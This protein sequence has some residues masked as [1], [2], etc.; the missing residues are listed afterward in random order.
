MEP[1]TSGVTDA[2]THAP[3]SPRSVSED[4][5]ARIK[6]CKQHLEN[7]CIAKAKTETLGI[8]EYPMR[9]LEKILYP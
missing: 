6:A 1:K 2:S 7:L 5:D 9:E 3:I 8:N 4:L